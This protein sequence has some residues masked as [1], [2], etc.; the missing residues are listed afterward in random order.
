MIPSRSFPAVSAPKTEAVPVEDIRHGIPRIDEFAWLRAR[1]WQE[2]FK[3][4]SLLAPE[5]R[6]H[7]EAE[8]E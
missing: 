6:A 4:P 2:V 5:I 8:N 7:L 3:D 1:N